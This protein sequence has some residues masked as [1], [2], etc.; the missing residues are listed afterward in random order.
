MSNRGSVGEIASRFSDPAFRRAFNAITPEQARALTAHLPA[1]VRA[2]GAAFEA[3]AVRGPKGTALERARLHME[4]AF[5]GFGAAWDK[6]WPE[7][8]RELAQ[9]AALRAFR[10]A[11]RRHERRARR[12]GM[13]LIADRFRRCRLSAP[14]IYVGEAEADY[15]FAATIPMRWFTSAPY[16]Y[17]LA[18]NAVAGFVAAGGAS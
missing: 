7:V 12:E 11:M 10:R 4:Q 13:Y 14:A 5:P 3:S 1:D 15:R 2:W 18:A 8:E 9:C 16:L 6:R 17:S